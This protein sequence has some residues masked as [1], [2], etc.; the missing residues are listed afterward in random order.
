MNAVIGTLRRVLHKVDQRD[1]KW[2]GLWPV[3]RVPPHYCRAEFIFSHFSETELE[4][5]KHTSKMLENRIGSN[6]ILELSEY[7]LSFRQFCQLRI[8]ML[9][10]AWPC[11]KKNNTFWRKKLIQ[12][13]F[14]DCRCDIWSKYK[15]CMSEC[16]GSRRRFALRKPVGSYSSKRSLVFSVD[17]PGRWKIST[18][19]W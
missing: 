11:Y 19:W 10:M 17:Q 2:Q 3:H 5:L 12:N 8:Y 9:H 7:H 15:A 1:G 16:W 13:T 14:A 4:M 6:G 18:W